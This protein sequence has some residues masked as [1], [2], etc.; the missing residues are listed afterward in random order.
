MI[1]SIDERL[2]DIVNPQQFKLLSVMASYMDE[3][4]QCCPTIQTLAKDCHWSLNKLHRIKRQ[5]IKLGLIKSE[6]RYYDE[7]DDGH[8]GQDSNL[9]TVITTLINVKY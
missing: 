5:L 9:Y 3:K 7:E 1:I 6:A 4:K 2:L 8:N